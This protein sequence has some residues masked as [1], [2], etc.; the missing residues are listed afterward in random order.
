ML[1]FVVG[2]EWSLELSFALT[3][4]SFEF[5]FEHRQF[6]TAKNFIVKLCF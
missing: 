5:E 4:P 6:E 2:D 1:F 3:Q